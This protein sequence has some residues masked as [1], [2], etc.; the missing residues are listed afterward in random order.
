MPPCEPALCPCSESLVSFVAVAGL[1]AVDLLTCVA[2]TA[3]VCVLLDALSL[4]GL[5]PEA[6]ARLATPAKS[7]F[8]DIQIRLLIF[9][10]FKS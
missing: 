4:E 10:Y 5:Q 9:V 2:D 8:V 6:S 7:S 1:V 3:L